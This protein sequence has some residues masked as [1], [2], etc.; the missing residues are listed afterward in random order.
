MT[1]NSQE[2]GHDFPAKQGKSK[3]NNINPKHIILELSFI[4]FLIIF[5]IYYKNIY[6]NLLSVLYIFVGLL[7]ISNYML[8]GE[9]NHLNNNY[10]ILCEKAGTFIFFQIIYIGIMI[11]I[12]RFILLQQNV[13]S[14]FMIYL[15]LLIFLI[16]YIPFLT[17]SLII[18]SQNYNILDFFNIKLY[19]KFLLYGNIKTVLTDVCHVILLILGGYVFLYKENAYVFLIP[20]IIIFL[21]V[22]LY[23]IKLYKEFKAEYT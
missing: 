22:L 16:C 10:F 4:S 3:N 1:D 6:I 9:K 11:F 5:S 17:S 7:S 14:D 18:Y 8:R 15:F 23:K 20:I 19:A 13:I 21:T 12:L 2:N